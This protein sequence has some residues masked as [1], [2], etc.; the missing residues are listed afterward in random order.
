MQMNKQRATIKDVADLAGVS[1]T[2]VTNVLHNRG[3]R[4]SVETREKVKRAIE[5][6]GYRPN[7]IARSL[8]R[9]R[10]NTLGIVVEHYGGVLMGNPY[11]A[12]LLDGVLFEATRNGYQ[13]KIIALPEPDIDSVRRQAEDGS[14]DGVILAAPRYQSVL[15][16][17]TENCPLPCVVAGSIPASPSIACVDVDDEGAVYRAVS[18]LID[19]GHR[20]IGFIAGPVDYWS[21]HQREQ[22]YLGALRDKGVHAENA[23]INRGDYSTQSGMAAMRE[24]LCVR[25][26]LTAVFCCNDWMALGAL[27]TLWREGV[28]VPQDLSLI[29]FDDVEPAS[30]ARPP[31]TTIRQPVREIGSKAAEIL[32]RRLRGESRSAER[33]IFPGE[34]ILRE[35]VADVNGHLVHTQPPKE[36]I[37]PSSVVPLT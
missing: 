15:L 25:P 5:Q 13:I 28:R 21:A 33:V 29:G 10:S 14:V 18:W 27:E 4:Y 35:S 16:D 36:K 19:L 23:W 32:L 22:G 3:Q 30:V 20:R 24:L 31:L 26:A 11:H 17:W 12:M 9:R 2:T 34:L 37:L 8:V 1:F 7:Q 6:L